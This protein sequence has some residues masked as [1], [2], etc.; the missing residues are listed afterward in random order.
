MVKL[1]TAAELVPALLTASIWKK[2]WVLGVRPL[3]V[4]VSVVFE[5][6]VTGVVDPF[7]VVT[8]PPT[9]CSAA[10]AL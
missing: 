9:Q 2:Y 1:I 7:T 3:S 8:V 5:L 10:Q 6:P 4:A